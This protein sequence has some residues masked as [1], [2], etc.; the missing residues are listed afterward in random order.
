LLWSIPDTVLA[1]DHSDELDDAPPA[2]ADGD[3]VGLAHSAKMGRHGLGE[4]Q[5]ED[6]AESSNG[7]QDGDGEKQSLPS[8]VHT[9]FIVNA[10][11]QKLRVGNV[12]NMPGLYSSDGQPRD[13]MLGTAP[14]RKIYFGVDRND[15]WIQADT[16]HLW[17]KGSMTTKKYLHTF[18]E[19]QRLR[20]GAVWGMPGL[21]ASDGA[22]RD[23]ILG[24][25]PNKKIYFGTHREDAWIQ[26][27][28]G[29]A[30]FKGSVTVKNYVHLFAEG[31]RLR[32]GS[33]WG[34]PG[35]FA[36]DGSPRDLILGTSAGQKV[37]FGVSKEDAYIE[38]GVGDLWL[39]G[40]L[41]V[42]GDSLFKSG[43]KTLR[44]GSIYGM[45]GIYSSDG[46]S[47][48]LAL[49][50]SSGRRIYFGVGKDNA[51]IQAGTGTMWLK[52]SL[53]TNE[54]AFFISQK[55]KL[56][57]GSVWGMPGLYASDGE[58]RDLALG[59]KDGRKIFFG[60]GK[61]DAWIQAGTGK[62]YFKGSMT[63][64]DNTYHEVS[65]QRLQVGAW[66][67]IPGLYSSDG[68][69]RD[70]ILG[71]ADNRKI[72]F[73]SST[74]D[75]YITAGEGSLWTKG[76][77]EAHDNVFVYANNN[78]LRLGSVWGLPGIFS[79][80]GAPRDMMIGTEKNKKI[81]FGFHRDDAWVEAGSGDSFFKGKMS[82]TDSVKVSS[83]GVSVSMGEIQGMP[84]L[85][86]SGDGVARDL[87]LATGAGKKVY[88]GHIRE[89][90]SIETGTGNAWFK[91]KMQSESIE[92]G[93]L[94]T[95]KSAVFEDTVTVK[96]NL[97]LLSAS[98]EERNLLEE[99]D[100]LREQNAVLMRT[101]EEMRM[102]MQ[103][104]QQ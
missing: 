99:M 3:D 21:Y 100:T 63:L 33:V 77:I 15:A 36:S 14:N 96:K 46:G 39:K 81:F 68:G 10:K 91:G 64:D 67:G 19:G 24:T 85:T 73:G 94:K 79:S 51:W 20:V 76:S 95:T 101:V 32:V 71:T 89:D 65:G 56:R 88:F 18:A 92:T 90:A 48:D 59:T 9:N 49:G 102:L 54:D 80:D 43:G 6:P 83:N 23:M 40:K 97:I 74:G 69:A 42:N 45:P 93:E 5:E 44:V 28:T 86:S 22:N 34:M 61:T 87:M 52:G 16:G 78:R 55:Q 29:H 50:T 98:N 75:A 82:V 1:G 47:E 70:L 72:Y 26:S 57:V 17:V 7:S 2:F 84:G 12:W 104:M 66:A 11:K 30:W 27:G 35:L 4:A 62:A 60:D 38:A 58:A 41:T 37:Y 53:T 103:E 8:E 13:L 25:A 31:Q